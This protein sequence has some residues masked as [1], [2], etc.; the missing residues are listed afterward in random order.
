MR[1]FLILLTWILEEECRVKLKPTMGSVM[2]DITAIYDGPILSPEGKKIYRMIIVGQKVMP[3]VHGGGERNWGFV[4]M[5]TRKPE[6]IRKVLRE[7]HYETKTRGER[8]LPA[9]R[10]AY[11]ARRELYHHSEEP[12]GGLTWGS[13][14]TSQAKGGISQEAARNL[15]RP[16]VRRLR[17]SRF[18]RL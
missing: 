9:A 2:L 7:T 10:P 5:V 4:D 6:E 12:R 13:R 8:E 15:P 3:E 11:R 14:L 18:S 1:R 17:P 16:K